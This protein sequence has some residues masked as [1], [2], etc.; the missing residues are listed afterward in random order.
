MICERLM[1]DYKAIVQE[2]VEALLCVAEIAD[3][4]RQFRERLR[5][6]DVQFASFITPMPYRHG[7]PSTS[8]SRSRPRQDHPPRRRV[9]VLNGTVLLRPAGA[10]CRRP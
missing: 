6:A 1:P 2:L 4:E 5:D 8:S 10:I 3:C 7:F 9:G